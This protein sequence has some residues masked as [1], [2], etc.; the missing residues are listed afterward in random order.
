MSQ[1]KP[2]DPLFS[3]KKFLKERRPERF[4]DSVRREIG[5]LDRGFLEYQL[6][7]LNR[8]NKE[9][10]FEDFAKKLCESAICPNLLEQT[11][12]V[13][14]GDGKVDTQ[15]FPVSEQV[16]LRWYVGVNDDAH[17]ERWAFAVS[18]QVEWK[19]KCRKDVLKIKGTDR[20]YVKAFF[21]TNQFTKGN[22]RSALED[23]LT[24][25]TEIDVRI[26]DRSWI[27]DQIFSLGLE[28]MA[29]ETLGIEVDW[30]REVQTG[31]ADYARELRLKEIEETIKATVNLSAISTEEVGEFLEAAI[32][33][34]ELEKP[35]VETRGRFDQAVAVTKKFGT[36]FQ[37]FKTH[38]QYA[39]A[40][41][42]WLE[43]FDLFRTEFLSS[44]AVAQTLDYASQWGDVVTLFGLYS[45]AFKIRGQGDKTELE[46]LRKQLRAA[47]HSIVDMDD[48]PSNSLMGE[49]YLQI[50][51]LYSIGAPEDADQIFSS[52]LDIFE[53]GENLIGFAHSELYHLVIELDDVMGDLESYEALLDYITQSFSDREG[54]SKAAQM[55]LNRGARRLD[56]RKPYEAIKLLGKSLAGLYQKGHEQELYGALN[57]LAKAY[58]EVDL[59]WAARASHLLA[60]TLATNEYWTEGELLPGQVFSFIR[61]AK[62][63]LRLGRIHAALAWWHLALLISQGF[64]EELISE[65]E[66]QRFDAFLSQIIV[67]SNHEVLSALANLPNWLVAHGLVV[68]ESTLLYVLGYEELAQENT[69]ET[70]EGLLDFIKMVRDVDL[71]IKPPPINLLAGRYS[72]LKTIVMGCEVEVSFP[73]R[74]PFLELAETISSAL[75]SI[76]ATVIVDHIVITE[77]RLV[78]EISVD[79]DEEISITHEVNDSDRDLVFEVL[80]S[81]FSN[82]KLNV[83]GQA[84]IQ[85]WLQE[86]L[87][88]VFS[89]IVHVKDSHTTLKTM[90]V[91][92]QVMQRA[93]SFSSCF[94]ALCHVFGDDATG[95]IKSILEMPEQRD[96]PLLRKEK[97]DAGFPKNP[98]K[99]TRVDSLKPSEGAPRLDMIDPE[100][101]RHGDYKHHGLIN[102]RLWNQATWNGVAFMSSKGTPPV[103][104]V[105][106]RNKGAAEKIFE[107][108]VE[109][110][111]KD[112][113]KNRLRVTI[114]RG[115]NQQNPHEYRVHLSENFEANENGKIMMVSRINT[116][117]PQSSVNLDRFLRDYKQAGEY[118]LT[119]GVIDQ[120]S[121]TPHL[122]TWKN[123]S[124]LGIRDLNVIQGWEVGRNSLDS[125]AIQSSDDP[126]I[127][128]GVDA[129]PVW[130]LLKV[131]K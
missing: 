99:T 69:N 20:G 47:L 6:D 29:I 22:Q 23:E 117:H 96:F 111:G 52:L 115:V 60:S 84:V 49:A 62:V 12:P 13:A 101:S 104:I 100:K 41:Y 67:N 130:Q 38:Y 124:Y 81:S 109:T 74:T 44:L 65:D 16:K 58:S 93:V 15:T 70:A 102:V 131:K 21:V 119:F 45:S 66:L 39:W 128:K 120:N 1:H 27:L 25:G 108:L 122:P 110:I 33:S 11:G 30:R 56:T 9:L 114:I 3:P 4:S 17:K 92:D 19:Q 73:N 121:S 90:F 72:S 75:E 113:P 14:G 55:W 28:E 10:A 77:K 71:G 103:L 82:R 91:E 126:I 54:R 42:W 57:F 63:E 87:I 97:W 43:D 116:M 59:L 40:A 86:F 88:D 80:C 79:D 31:I 24:K 32:L 50:M 51:A 46:S 106:F 95:S 129:P 5:R 89:R 127:P 37:Q 61:L 64:K 98:M 78:I 83:D 34:K 7:T 112:D 107:E 85:Q 26:L 94:T 18:T 53:R 76:L 68:S 125:V 123:G 36:V 118:V 48:R 8:R 35:E 2:A 105:L